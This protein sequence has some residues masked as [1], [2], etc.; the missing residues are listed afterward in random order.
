MAA[1]RQDRLAPGDLSD[2][3]ISIRLVDGV[4][5][6]WNTLD[7]SAGWQANR[8]SAFINLRN[9]FDKA[10]RVYSSGVDGYGRHATVRLQYRLSPASK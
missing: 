6:G 1:G 4:M 9:L 3:R 7:V 10:Y 8:W 2:P 5:P